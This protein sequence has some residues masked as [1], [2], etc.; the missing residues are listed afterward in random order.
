MV[1]LRN[2]FRTLRL[3]E[4]GVWAHLYGSESV[5]HWYQKVIHLTEGS[6]FLNK[7]LV[8]YSPEKSFE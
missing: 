5:Y 2:Q 1:V 4:S 6:R 8:P 3:R 7:M